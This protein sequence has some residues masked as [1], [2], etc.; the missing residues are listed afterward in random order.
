MSSFSLIDGSLMRH[1]TNANCL[2]TTNPRIIDFYTKNPNISFESVNTI[3]VELLENVSPNITRS[4]LESTILLPEEKR[5][6]AELTAFLEKIREALRQQIQYISEKYIIAK[7]EY[8]RDFESTQNLT[9]INR[10]FLEKTRSLLFA[11]GKIRHANIAEK[12]QMMLKKFEQILSLNADAIVSKPEHSPATKDYLE[13]FESNANHMIQAIIQ[14]LIDCAKT[15]EQRVK[16]MIETKQDNNSAAYYKLIYDLNDLLHQI[17]L[18][19]TQSTGE[20]FQFVLSQT[21]PTATIASGEESEN[22]FVLLRSDKPSI[23]IETHKMHDRNINM[24]E[25]KQFIRSLEEQ[26]MNGILIS[27]HTGISDKPHFHIEIN[28]NRIVV[29]LHKMEYSADKLQIA[30]DIIDT[31]TTKLTD[32]FFSAE[33]KYSI[34]KETLDDVNREYQHF[35]IQKETILTMIKDQHK[36]LL[37]QIDDMRFTS[38]DK[39]LSTRYSSCKKQGFVCDLCGIFTVSTL[40]GLAA[41]KRGCARKRTVT[42]TPSLKSEILKAVF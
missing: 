31:L 37:G 2:Q 5:K 15:C 40:K 14:L 32:F 30:V 28:S 9:Q 27:Q 17:P 39:F 26:N 8:I 3:L 19:E 22:N 35:I 21:F 13:N 6:T 10:S 18:T 29:Y 20:S 25:V 41:H 24:G 34:P 16:E 23:C 33:N 38:L 11:V 42:D 36:R 1:S 7:T 12:S 4:Q